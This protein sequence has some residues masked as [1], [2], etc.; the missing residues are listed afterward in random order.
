MAGT[1]WAI[2]AKPPSKYLRI[3]QKTTG[4]SESAHLEMVQRDWKSH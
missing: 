2:K 1:T 3:L 4:E